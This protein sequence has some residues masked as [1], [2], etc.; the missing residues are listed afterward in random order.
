MIAVG[1]EIARARRRALGAAAP[2]PVRALRDRGPAP[3]L[4]QPYPWSEPRRDGGVIGLSAAWARLRPGADVAVVDKAR[5][6][7][8]ASGIAGG[9]VR[10]YYRAA[11]I[12]EIVQLSVELFEEDPEA[13][14]FSQVGYVAAVPPAAGRRPEGDPCAPRAGGLRVELV[15][16]SAAARVPALDVAGL[17]GAGGG[18][19]ARA[20]GRVGGR[21]ADGAPPARAARGGRGDP[22]GRRGGRVRGRPGLD[23]AGPIESTPWCWR[24]AFWRRGCLDLDLRYWKAQEGEFVLAGQGLSGRAGSEAPVVH[25]DQ[26][27]PR[28]PLDGGALVEG[29]WGIYFRMGRT[30]RDHGRRAAGAA[31]GAGADPYGPDNASTRQTDSIR[32]VLHVRAGGGNA[33]VPRPGRQVAKDTRRAGS[34]PTRPLPDLR[35]GGGERLRDGGHRPRLQDAGDQ[36]PGGGRERAA[37]RTPGWTCS[38][39]R[40]SSA[41]S[42]WRRRRGRIRGRASGQEATTPS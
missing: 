10:N 27:G 8:G 25:L 40:G 23:P 18:A 14:G 11:A 41:A 37:T 21:D 4:E 3:G 35:L 9:I 29:P 32:G 39:R 30:E 15:V 12:S 16:G 5:L 42:C 34:C 7:G 31:R 1:R 38:E 28:C 24:R 6:G 22:R 2:V 17:G 20:P 19:A 33:A 13:Y 36:Q 26:A